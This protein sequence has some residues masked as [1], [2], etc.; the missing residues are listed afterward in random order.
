MLRIVNLATATVLVAGHGRWKCPA[1][2][3]VLDESGNHI[4]FDNTGNKVLNNNTITCKSQAF[5]VCSMWARVWE[6]GIWLSNYAQ[7][8]MDY[9]YMG[10]V[11]NS[12]RFT[13]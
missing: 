7:A 12:Y 13:I 5:S 4:T 11:C 2:R 1:A 6:V 9:F 10:G 3:D 8:R